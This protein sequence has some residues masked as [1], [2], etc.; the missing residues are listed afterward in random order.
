MLLRPSSNKLS[1]GALV[2]FIVTIAV[3][4]GKYDSIAPRGS[5]GVPVGLATRVAA[6]Q[7]AHLTWATTESEWL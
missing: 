2:P 5:D 6:A 3:G 4:S 7:H 1:Q